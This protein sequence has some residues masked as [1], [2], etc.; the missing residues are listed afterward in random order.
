MA[1][2]C[3]CSYIAR[4]TVGTLKSREAW[5]HML[6]RSP[7]YWSD[8]L[9]STAPIALDVAW[10]TPQGSNVQGTLNATHD[11]DTPEQMV[12]TILE[13]PS[14][15]EVTLQGNSF[16]YMPNPGFHG[17][18]AFVFQVQCSFPDA[19]FHHVLSGWEA[20]WSFCSE[21][22]LFAC[23]FVTPGLRWDGPGL[24]QRHSN[25]HSHTRQ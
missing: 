20:R 8:V 22:C 23:S 4:D 7:K 11:Y 14:N 1:W 16:E 25:D 9:Q 17:E 13:S 21:F 18:D 15:G 12:F 24:Q 3:D 2:K 19:N 6:V 10:Q 5:V